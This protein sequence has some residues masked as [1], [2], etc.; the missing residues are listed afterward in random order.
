MD[1]IF[2]DS[3][4]PFPRRVDDGDV[5]RLLLEV[6]AV[7]AAAEQALA[8]RDRNRR[9]RADVG[10]RFRI[11]GVEHECRQRLPG[12]GVLA[13]DRGPEA[14]D[15]RRHADAAEGLVVLA[16]PD[17]AVVGRDLEEIEV[18][19]AGVGVKRFDRCDFHGRIVA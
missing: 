7:I 4:T 1:A 8:G 14:G 2:S 18:A 11:A 12:A 9:A 15:G 19:L 16:P 10:Q 17:Q 6:R 5:D 13:D 3:A